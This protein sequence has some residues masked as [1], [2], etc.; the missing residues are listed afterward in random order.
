MSGDWHE[1]ESDDDETIFAQGRRDSRVYASR[2]FPLNRPGSSD[3]GAPARFVCKVFDPE[4]ESMVD[5]EVDQWVIRETPAGRYQ[6]K[7]L[8][9]RVPGNVKDLW[10]QRVPAPG[11]SGTTTVLLHL[12][13]PE[14]SKLVD[15][16]KLLDAFPVEG[17]T[18]VRLDDSLIHDLLA[19]PDSLTRLYRR[20]PDQ[21]RSL[22]ASD[23]TAKDV[24]ALEARRQQLERFG[25]LLT[26]GEFFDAEVELTARRR[27]EDVWQQL[28]ESNPWMLGVTLTGQLLTSWD[29]RKLEQ[30]VAGASILSVGKRTDALMRTSGR[31]SSMVF[32]EIKT[33]RTPLLQ[34]EYRS[35]CWSPSTELIGAIAQLQGTVHRAVTQIGERIAGVGI[36]R[37]EIPGDYAYLLRPRSFVLAGN[38]S[39]LRGIDGGDNLDKIRSFELFRN[40]L[41]EPEILTFDEVLAR[42]E[43]A[44]DLAEMDQ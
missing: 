25:R 12:E 37:S 8:V 27:S 30:M 3:H 36:D 43:W 21:V 1:F 11:Q 29:D 39:E 33:H 9:A 23:S 10:I 13:Q 18:T 28:F 19:D 5:Q 24:L 2:S 22:I 15:L 32:T 4:T 40:Q 14:I 16:V 17:D 31:I 20:A 6:I 38:L 35:G 7:L 41:Q 44:L 26:D 34:E 42:A